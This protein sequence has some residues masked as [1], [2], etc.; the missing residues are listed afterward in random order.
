MSSR[1]LTAL[2]LATLGASACL[3]PQDEP[4]T[5][6]DLRVLGASFDPPD[7]LIAGC[8]P[9]LLSGLAGAA[10]GGAVTL[11]PLLTLAIA[12]AAARPLDYKALIADPA[13]GGRALQY[14]LLGCASSGDRTCD[15]AGDYVELTTG[16][17]TAGE[18]A[19]RVTPGLAILPDGQVNALTDAGTPLLL[20]VI[21]QDTFKGL[22][23]V[24][25]PVVL[26]LWAPG[27]TEHIYAQK[28]MVYACQFFPEMKPNAVPRL[29]GLLWNG[30][31]WPEGEIKDVTGRTPVV[32][33][34][35]DFSTLEEDYLVASLALQPVSLRESWKINWVT[36]SGT[37]APYASGG[38]DFSGTTGRHK[39]TWTPDPKATTPSNVTFYFV[40]RDG[41]GGESWLT[42]QIRWTPE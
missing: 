14:R 26:D 7:V 25:V 1:P 9:A 17:T 11:D 39:S 22:G 29:P 40:V 15:N 10:D 18:L 3:P 23:G 37:M 24:R 41:R 32:I 28:L 30:E 42:R 16:Q 35:D 34:P 36:T 13:G 27:T 2:V 38:T 31:P 5:A 20:E 12:F 8:N 33:T 19:L 6:H 21:N 4:T